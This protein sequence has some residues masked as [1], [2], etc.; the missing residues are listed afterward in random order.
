MTN[1]LTH[2]LRQILGRLEAA[3]DEAASVP[4]LS[5][6]F[7]AHMAGLKAPKVAG[8]IRAAL[9]H[10]ENR[11]RVCDTHGIV[12]VPL[13]KQGHSQRV[14]PIV[15]RCP[16]CDA[17]SRNTTGTPK[18][19]E[20]DPTT[21]DAWVSCMIGD[22][23]S[24]DT[25][26]RYLKQIRSVMWAM[27]DV[28]F[29]LKIPR[30]MRV[31]RGRKS[32]RL[33]PE[34]DLAGFYRATDSATWKSGLWWRV[35][36]SLMVTYG[37]RPSTA[38]M[39]LW[40]GEGRYRPREGVYFGKTAPHDELRQAGVEFPHGS[41]VVIPSKESGSKPD[42]LVLPQSKVV[43]QNLWAAS[44]QLKDDTGQVL[45]VGD[46]R[47]SYAL[48]E[49]QYRNAFRAIQKAGGCGDWTPKHL[50]KTF[51]TRYGTQF[52]PEDARFVSG[53]ADRSISGRH[54]LDMTVRIIDQIDR[55]ELSQLLEAV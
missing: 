17:S 46:E 24:A 5:Q 40:E 33:V 32:I 41:I 19:S 53:H 9:T 1:S 3:G 50:R 36:L 28:D 18:A 38:T 30:R 43:R 25:C 26:T 29:S 37:W 14:Q 4:T 15:R 13:R 47:G 21:F 10:L 34:K 20:F 16:K 23:F 44:R 31:P 7:E 27:V 49:H 39:L 48:R 12:I 52:T 22:T 6:F 55:F 35:W 2:E 42:P 8:Q 51:E 11:V 54:Y 45:P